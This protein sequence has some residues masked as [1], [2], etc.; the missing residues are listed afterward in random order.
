MEAPALD[1]SLGMKYSSIMNKRKEQRIKNL[2]PNGKPRWVRCYDN[3]GESVDRYTVCYT[4]RYTHKTGRQHWGI[5]M[6][7]HPFHPQGVGMHFEYP[8]QVDCGQGRDYKWP[9]AIGRKCHLGRRI[10]FDDL[11][12]DCQKCVMQDYLYLWD[13]PGGQSHPSAE[14]PFDPKSTFSTM[15][16][17]ATA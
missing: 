10:K 1:I 13:L 16:K 12:P 4:G 2:L 14:D 5:G 17:S 9:P 3:G 7:A 8:Y 11:P 15:L 6:S